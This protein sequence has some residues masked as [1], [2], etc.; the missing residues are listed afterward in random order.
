MYKN[1]LDYGEI[2][3]KLLLLFFFHVF[4]A[5]NSRKVKTQT[6]RLKN[7]EI[8][9]KENFPFPGRSRKDEKKTEKQAKQKKNNRKENFWGKSWKYLFHFHCNET[10]SSPEFNECKQQNCLNIIN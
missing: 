4:T 5:E 3:W 9:K 2:N 10:T 1:L 7:I 8:F 6:R